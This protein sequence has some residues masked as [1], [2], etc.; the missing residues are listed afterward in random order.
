MKSDRMRQNATLD[1][2]SPAQEAAVEAMLAGKTVTEA[3]L[4]GGVSRAS[5][6]RWL[7]E[8]FAF[9]AEL[10]R[11]RREI[12]RAAFGTLERIAT[13][14]AGCLEKAL[15]EGDV[16]AALEVLKRLQL[17]APS[18]I[19]SDDPAELAEEAKIDAAARQ[20]AN[21]FRAMQAQLNG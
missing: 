9:Q 13:K 17:L 20:G 7:K 2:I 10:N 11:G 14:A 3:A 18:R 15:D 1:S 6:H 8:D 19:G 16:K 5:V 12:R 21:E 4:A